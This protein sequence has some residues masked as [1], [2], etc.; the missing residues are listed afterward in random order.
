MNDLDKL[1]NEPEAPKLIETV[2]PKQITKPTAAANKAHCLA[3]Q[4]NSIAAASVGGAVFRSS[5]T[6]LVAGP[7]VLR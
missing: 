7:E 1:L 6:L 4:D 3:E 5:K 2:I